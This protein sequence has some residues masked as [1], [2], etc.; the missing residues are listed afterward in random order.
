MMLVDAVFFAGTRVTSIGKDP[1][2]GF[3]VLNLSEK[4]YKQVTYVVTIKFKR[5]ITEEGDGFHLASVQDGGE[6]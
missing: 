6:K 2:N 4:L 1:V 5:F 3:I